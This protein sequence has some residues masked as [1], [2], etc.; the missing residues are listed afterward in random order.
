MPFT[1]FHFGP[2]LG[3]GL[4]L[5]RYLHFPTFIL[6]NVILDIEP[7][8]VFFLRLRY[9]L[10]GYLHTILSA[11]IVGLFLGYVMFLLERFLY[12]LYK[13]FLLEV[14]DLKLKSFIAAGILGTVLHIFLDAPLYDDIM[15]FYPLKVNPLYN[16]SITLEVYNFCIWMGIL[17][18]IY[19]L[20]LLGL[21]I[22]RKITKRYTCI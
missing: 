10:H 4:P 22:Y 16:P 6:A 17:G 2:S 5:R 20:C 3:F 8:L 18:V 11:V 21:T 14:V 13:L 1:P 12:P 19:Y 9:P 15:P 7:F